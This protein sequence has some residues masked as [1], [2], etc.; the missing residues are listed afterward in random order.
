MAPQNPVWIC[1]AGETDT[2]EVRDLRLHSPEL[3]LYD[4]DPKATIA[5]PHL[6]Q[7]GGNWFVRKQIR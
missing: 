5:Y 3:F 6:F 7:N 1:L 2:L 4:T